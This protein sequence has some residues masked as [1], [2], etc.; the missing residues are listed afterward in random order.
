MYLFIDT[1]Y[2]DNACIALVKGKKTIVKRLSSDPL[3]KSGDALYQIDS[4]LKK[5]SM[6]AYKLQGIIV[7]IG[8]GQF[9]F[10]RTGIA[11]AN[12]FGF[13]I[14]IPIAGLEKPQGVEVHALIKRGLQMLKQ[15][16]QFSFVA[17]FYG[18]EP[19]I[20]KPWTSLTHD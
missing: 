10:L 17:P 11:I 9:S 1:A 5:N 6:S 4:L 2:R 14:H 18:K 16:E 13:A 15:K 19:N 20:T 7:V 3:K 12:T 8:P